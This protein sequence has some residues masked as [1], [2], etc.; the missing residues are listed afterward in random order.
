[1]VRVYKLTELKAMPTLCRGEFEDMKVEENYRRVW[2][3]HTEDKVIVE[4]YIGF[5]WVVA[6]E[7]PVGDETS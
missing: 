5:A 3:S 1:M 7:Y 4:Q 6:Y 2:L